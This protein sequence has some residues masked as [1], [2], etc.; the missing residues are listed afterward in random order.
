LPT[1]LNIHL[2]RCTLLN[3]TVSQNMSIDR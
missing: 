1:V 3:R 2:R